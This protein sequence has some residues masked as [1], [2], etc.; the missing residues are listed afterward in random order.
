M[1]F[2][3]WFSWWQKG[4]GAESERET[5][6]SLISRGKLLHRLEYLN[7]NLQIL[8]TIEKLISPVTLLESNLAGLAKTEHG[9]KTPKQSVVNRFSSK[10][11]QPVVSSKTSP[12][13]PGLLASTLF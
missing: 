10:S 2:S 9:M 11:L 13:E 6:F 3:L 8:F 7:W 12:H 1:R 5:E 4:N